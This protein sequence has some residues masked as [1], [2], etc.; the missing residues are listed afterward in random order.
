MPLATVRLYLLCFAYYRFGQINDTLIE[1]FIHLV[2][3]YEQQA[4]QAAE[5]ARQRAATAV[6]EDLQAAGQVLSLFV[7][8]AIPADVPFMAVQE[9]AFALLDPA[10]FPAVSDYMRNIAFD[11]TGFEWSFYTTLSPTF[12]R[13]LRHLFSDL[14]FVGRVEDAPLLEGIA[15]LQSLLR[16]GKSPRQ[17]TP[18]LFPTALIPKMLQRYL[19]AKG[20]GKERILE[21]DRYEFLLYRLLRNA[22]EAGGV[23]VRESTEF[24]RFED[25]LISDTRWQDKETILQEIGAPL[26]LAPIQDTLQAIFAQR[27]EKVKSA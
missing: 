7:D 25:D 19:F 5:D 9:K 1:A 18:S 12:K 3:H 17:T 10:R 15:F 13:N 24:R 27:T 6:G 14:D 23:F 21:V 22:L 4:K 16:Q 2:D 11:K 26:L 20:A 8:A